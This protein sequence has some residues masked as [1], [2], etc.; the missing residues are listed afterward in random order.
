MLARAWCHKMNYFFQLED[1]TDP[2]TPLEA[3]TFA[4]YEE[5]AEFTLFRASPRAL[6]NPRLR[7]VSYIRRLFSPA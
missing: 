1:W 2:P 5:P 6:Q 7:R 4:R 3:A